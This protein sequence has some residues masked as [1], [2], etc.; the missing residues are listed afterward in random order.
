[1]WRLASRVPAAK[2]VKPRDGASAR[3]VS[4]VCVRLRDCSA[5]EMDFAW[6]LRVFVNA[7]VGVYRGEVNCRFGA[8]RGHTRQLHHDQN[9]RRRNA[10][11]ALHAPALVRV[12]CQ[13]RK[14]ENACKSAKSP[15][16]PNTGAYKTGI[17]ATFFAVT[18]TSGSSTVKVTPD[19]DRSNLI[20][21]AGVP[22]G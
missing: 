17:Q 12:R 14:R 5:I 8:P 20:R 4:D 18:T 7:L 15:E 6:I 3:P 2:P 9:H 21:T 16:R 11:D 10:E 19:G 22:T 1:M 13:V